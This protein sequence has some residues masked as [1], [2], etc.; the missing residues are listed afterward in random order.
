MF[1]RARAATL[2]II[3]QSLVLALVLAFVLPGAHALARVDPD[4]V[5]ISIDRVDIDATLGTDGSLQVTEVRSFTG[6]FNGVY[7]YVPLGT[8]KGVDVDV[9]VNEVGEV[10]NGSLQPF[11][12]SDSGQDGTYELTYYDDAVRIKVYSEHYHSRARLLINYTSTNVAR[13]YDDVSEL[14]WQFVTEG[15]DA[16]S[17][18]VTCTVHLPVPAGKQITP[19]ENVR[20]WGHGPLD[21]TVSFDGDDVVYEIPGVGTSEFAE[22]RIVM[23]DDWLSNTTSQGGRVLQDILDEEQ[24]WADEANAR[25]ER[26]RFLL[27]GGFAIDLLATI[28]TIVGSL[29]AMAR[30][31]KTHR[32]QFDDTYF[33]DVPTDD[34]P[35]V[36][37][38]LWRGGEASDEDFTATLMRLT[39]LGAI[40]ID[41]VETRQKARFGQFKTKKDYKLTCLPKASDMT[42]D[43]IDRQALLTL[44]D[45]IGRLAPKHEGDDPQ[46]EVVYFGDLETVGKQHPNQFNRAYEDWTSQVNAT[47]ISRKFFINDGPTGRAQ[48][49]SCIALAIS[50]SIATV[51]LMILTGAWGLGA[52]L[53]LAQIVGT[54][55]GTAA[56][57]KCAPV[58][59]E[60]IE[61]KAKLD[62]LRR[63]LKD[64]TRLEEAVP[65]DVVLW[66]RLLVMA[67]VLGVADEVIKQLK[68]AVPEIFEDPALAPMYHWYGGNAYGSRPYSS[69]RGSYAN[70]HSVSAAAVA[71]SQR[72]SGGG[73]GGGFSGGGGGG[74]G[75]GGGGHSG[76]GAF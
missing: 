56:V 16:E 47:A 29:M 30:Y 5:S 70:A 69:F 4:D 54:M 55:I 39:D 40:T 34:H 9:Q 17:K 36:L 11:V 64:F 61:I 44:F 66:D 22:A 35:A 8:Y 57:I 67:V 51:F 12:Q 10:V 58:S 38:A 62:A 59:R 13:R 28:A 74:F 26:A 53:L 42:L 76:G 20:A 48:A 3:V 7:W 50:L 52:L 27:I 18:N 23:P 6:S 73:G 33:R 72:S 32:P 63:W 41:S 75:G 46:A 14:Y 45:S 19:E 68:V 37:G 1:S 60:A 65:R 43:K 2:R 71:A 49:A 25:R 31:R 15:W 24:R 21:A